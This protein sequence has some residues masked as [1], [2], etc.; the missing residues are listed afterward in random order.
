MKYKYLCGIPKA[1]ETLKELLRSK[2]KL[3]AT[4]Y[5][6]NEISLGFGTQ[7]IPGKIIG[8]HDKNTSL[9]YILH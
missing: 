3:S 1:R 7:S 8:L 4:F 9:F 6:N 2:D 5:K